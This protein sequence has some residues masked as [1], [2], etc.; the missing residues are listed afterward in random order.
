MTRALLVSTG[1]S[2]SCRR[3]AKRG[4]RV[5][6]LHCQHAT[7]AP[8]VGNA[9]RILKVV[10]ESERGSNG[11]IYG[12]VEAWDRLVEVSSSALRGAKADFNGAINEGLA[13]A[14]SK[15][16]P[17]KLPLYLCS[18]DARTVLRGAVEALE[19][20]IRRACE[21][22]DL[23]QLLILSRLCVELPDLRKPEPGNFLA[24]SRRCQNADLQILQSGATAPGRVH[25]PRY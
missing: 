9:D 11:P 22:H 2:S 10:M 15:P 24:T 23:R 8:I 16:E 20:R 25:L 5:L 4:S 21:V 3:Q 13:V 12:S 19:R 17:P 14:F 18:H 1:G 6:G 7:A